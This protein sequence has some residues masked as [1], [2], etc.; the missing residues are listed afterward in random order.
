MTVSRSLSLKS[1]TKVPG[2]FDIEMLVTELAAIGVRCDFPGQLQ[3]LRCLVEMLGN[4]TGVMLRAMLLLAVESCK[5]D[6]MDSNRRTCPNCLT[7][8]GV[9]WPLTKLSMDVARKGAK[10]M[11]NATIGRAMSKEQIEK[12]RAE[13]RARRQ[14]AKGAKDYFTGIKL[15]D[16]MW[17]LF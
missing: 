6:A 4:A 16:G 14:E 2:I 5:I 12:I 13:R 11:G 17:E 15:W 8:V 9:G 7:A 1:K 3:R 10:R